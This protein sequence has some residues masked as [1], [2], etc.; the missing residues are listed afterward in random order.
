LIPAGNVFMSRTPSTSG[1][2]RGARGISR[3][4]RRVLP[5]AALLLLLLGPAAPPARSAT[6]DLVE[7]Q[8]I[9]V[10]LDK[11][12]AMGL[13]PGFFANTRP[14]DMQAVRETVD[15]VSWLGLTAHESAAGMGRWVAYRS[16]SAVVA[17]AGLNLS[18]SRYGR[19]EDNSGAT[20]VPDD[21]GARATVFGRYEPSSWLSL[22]GKAIGWTGD[23]RGARGAGYSVQFG[24][25]YASLQAGEITAWYGP[26]RR[27]GLIFT[28]NAESYPGVRLHNPVPI[29]FTG[30]FSFL[31][32]FQY[33]WFFAQMDEDRPVPETTLSGMRIALRPNRYLEI[34]ATRAMHFGGEGRSN[35]FDAWWDAFRGAEDDVP[36][37]RNQLGGF[38][39]TLTLPFKAMPV[40][41]YVEAAGEDQSRGKGI[42]FIPMPEKWSALG[43]IFFPALFGNPDFDFRIEYADN[44]FNNEGYIWYTHSYSPHEYKGRILG[45][46]MGTDARDLMVQG[47]W[48]F[49]PST[50]L[51]FTVDVTNRFY[52]GPAEEKTTG[53]RTAFLGWLTPSVRAGTGLLVEQVRNAGGVGGSDRNE[54]AA[55][56]DLSWQYSGGRIHPSSKEKP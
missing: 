19:V 52:P 3:A 22:D 37:V 26:G 28:N 10:V 2:A 42:E 4:A 29:P 49:L 17:R 36:N 39:A 40:Q 14:Y 13:L 56:I 31:G 11:L 43:G 44:H 38:D 53:F 47:R 27:G 20:P 24:H 55:W 45:H 8:E 1:I 41:L 35:G 25:R 51:E 21:A 48:F 15:S 18:Y 5:F 46:P 34:G 7:E 33:D 32:H 9:Y 30:I 23:D 16:R 12:N 50:Y 6:L 54:F